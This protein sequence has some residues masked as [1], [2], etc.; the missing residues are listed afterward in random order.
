MPM[1]PARAAL[2]LENAKKGSHFIT[3]IESE[4]FRVNHAEV[5]YHIARSWN[6][7]E[8]ITTAIRYHHRYDELMARRSGLSPNVLTLVSLLKMAEHISESF[9][10]AA[11][12]AG[13]EDNEWNAASHQVLAHFD[14]V[15]DDF[16]DLEAKLLLMLGQR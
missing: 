6:L 13:H 8:E 3:E 15:D 4:H 5:G 1:V 2:G 7:P 11:F 14:L 9:R 16:E 10:A 12:R